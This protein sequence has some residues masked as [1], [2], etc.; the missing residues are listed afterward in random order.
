MTKTR[1]PAWFRGSTEAYA[2][3]VE[4][5]RLDDRRFARQVLEV[6]DFEDDQFDA[7]RRREQMEEW[8]DDRMQAAARRWAAANPERV[9]PQLQRWLDQHPGPAPAAA[10]AAPAAAEPDFELQAGPH[11]AGDLAVLAFDYQEELSAPFHLEVT[12]VPKEG[13]DPDATALVAQPACLGVRLGDGSS[14]FVDGIVTGVRRWDEGRVWSDRRLRL[15][16]EPRLARLGWITRSRIFQDLS[17]PEIVE[18]VLREGGIASDRVEKRLAGSY[19]K[20]EFC[21]QY[22]ETDLDFVHRLLED[23]GIFYSFQ[24]AQGS[25]VLV[26][27]DAPSAH[28]PIAG[29]GAILPFREPGGM[30]AEE[31]VDGLQAT[32]E[33]LPGK[34]TLRDFDWKRPA[35]DLTRSKDTGGA[36]ADLEVYEYP[37][38]YDDP[39]VGAARARLRLEEVRA[40]AERFVGTTGCRRLEAG[41]TF[42]LQDHPVG[43]L[44][45]ELLLVSVSAH[46][47]QADPR[48]RYRCGFVA[49][50]K[51]VPFRPERRTPA[52]VAFGAETATVVGPPGEEIHTDHF[53]RIKVKFHWDREGRSDEHAS[54][55]MRVAQAWAGPGWGALFLPR[56]GHEVVVEFHDGDPDRP[57][58]TGSVYNGANPP[59]LSLPDDKTKSTL[60]SA[61]SPGSA[62]ANELRFEDAAGA[63]EVY[64]HAQKDLNVRVEND[65]AEKVGGNDRLEVQGDRS[66]TVRGSQQLQVAKNDTTQV[67]GSQAAEIGGS[68]TVTVGAAHAETIGASQTITV[69]AAQAVSVGAAAA[70]SV[71]GMKALTVGA[72]YAVTVGGAMNEIVG[73]LKSEEIGGAKVETVG[74]KKTETVAGNRSLSVGKD[75]QETVGGKRTLKV[76]KDVTVNVAGK[77]QQVA[78]KAWTYK[79]KEIVLAADEKLTIKA[80]S[81]VIEVKK[82]GD[83]VVKGKKVELKASG[84]LVLKGSKI[85]EN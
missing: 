70:E 21:V 77:L 72:A 15:T 9:P 84:D 44:N 28:D 17:V 51:G 26:L 27:A 7:T 66:V 60:R 39:G 65:R 33:V 22:R 20:R 83:V 14:R 80:G 18:Q 12:A 67:G 8:L 68:R 59:P 76:G 6:P 54:C 31:H 25:H 78:K 55:W 79:A 82:N 42:E 1:K 23:E 56:I 74:G 85:T 62:G 81:A 13:V 47:D 34:L 61:T 10:V 3:Q 64:L 4:R 52:P 58:V 32:L 35:L 49:Q 40:R 24:H 69:G 19:R 16:V 37:G 11:P 45:G 75:L 71:G 2:M 53:G 5:D 41:R 48:Q 43:A 30:V 36:D 50:R 73:A 38:G 63:E 57:I 29:G 46:G